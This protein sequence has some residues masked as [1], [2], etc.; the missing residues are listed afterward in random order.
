MELGGNV[1]QAVCFSVLICYVYAPLDE[2]RMKL[3]LCRYSLLRK[4]NIQLLK[5]E[6]EFE[7]A[8]PFYAL[9]SIR[10]LRG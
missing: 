6:A 3:H 5:S 2:Q 1:R 4:A 7:M 8:L 9:L 10:N